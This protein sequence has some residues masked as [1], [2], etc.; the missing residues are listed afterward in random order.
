[1]SNA[2]S[3]GRALQQI[4]R[5]IVVVVVTAAEQVP[6]L[7][8]CQQQCRRILPKSIEATVAAVSSGRE[9]PVTSTSARKWCRTRAKAEAPVKANV[10]GATSCRTLNTTFKHKMRA[11]KFVLIRHN[12]RFSD[13]LF[14]WFIAAFY[15]SLL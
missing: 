1:M 4:R 2:L 15:R 8:K 5:K 3:P 7:E 11:L 14:H 12:P 6:C 9:S 10:A 13:S